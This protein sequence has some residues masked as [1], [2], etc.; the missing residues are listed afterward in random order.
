MTCSADTY[1]VRLRVLAETTLSSAFA[2]ERACPRLPD[3]LIAGVDNIYVRDLRLERPDA[4][5]GAPAL[6]TR[7]P[8]IVA[9]TSLEARHEARAEVS[10]LDATA[11]ATLPSAQHVRH[12]A[13]MSQEP[14]ERAGTK[15]D[16]T[17]RGGMTTSKHSGR[18]RGKGAILL[19]VS[20]R[21]AWV[22]FP[23]PPIR[24]MG[25]ALRGCPQV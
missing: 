21:P 9:H 24:M 3:G 1:K 5:H 17:G 12:V 6:T 4:R 8:S 23:P 20:H 15:R 10:G 14:A 19:G 2:T 13:R 7:G 11:L 18:L 16:E 22:R 25:G